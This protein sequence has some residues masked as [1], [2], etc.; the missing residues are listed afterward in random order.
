M[1]YMKKI[2]APLLILAALFVLP[3]CSEKFNIAA[4]YKS[5]TVINGLLDKQDTAHYIRVEKA[6]LDQNKSALAMAKVPDSSFYNNITVRMEQIN[7]LDGSVFN[8]ITLQRVDLNNEGYPKAEGTFFDAPNYAYKFKDALDPNY[9]YRIVVTNPATG[10]TDSADAPVID[11]VNTSVFHVPVLGDDTSLNLHGMEFAS[12]NPYQYFEIS[13]SYNPFSSFSF[14]N[15]STPAAIV[16]A[17]VRFN[18]VD[19]SVQTGATSH[20][21]Y[22]LN[23]GTI[24][25]TR[26]DFDFQV[27]N[28][29][30]YNAVNT[31]LG[32]PADNFTVRLLD[33]CQILVYAGTAD[34]N[35]Y[36]QV[37]AVQGTGLTGNEVEPTYT[38]VKGKNVL[39]L[40]TSRGLRSGSIT[41]TTVTVDSLENSALTSRCRIVGTTY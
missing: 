30:L 20:H 14:Q 22:D 5:I 2:V 4:P 41:L 31:G 26:N 1:S 21:S 17:Y 39:G 18:W 12:T 6:F 27:K 9:I 25:V 40:Y 35:T 11:D 16:Q 36:L 8:T 28:L 15:S 34:F 32:A 38:N 10:E 23:V 19:S 37:A 13:G 29:T 33:R 24:G 3:A 7:M